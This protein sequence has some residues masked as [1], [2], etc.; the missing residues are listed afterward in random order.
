VDLDAVRDG[1]FEPLIVGLSEGSDEL[2]RSLMAMVIETVSRVTEATG[3]VVAT[4]GEITF[5]A[6][7]QALDKMEWSLTDDNELSLPAFVMHPDTV[8]KLPPQTPEQERAM[9]ELKARKL[10]ELLAQRRRRRLS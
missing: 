1:N 5:E 3:N 9:E 4:G 2:A 10:E 6:I 7:Y 8:E